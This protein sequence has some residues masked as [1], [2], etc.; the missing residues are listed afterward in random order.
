MWPCLRR[1][2]RQHY[3]PLHHYIF[4]FCLWHYTYNSNISHICKIIMEKLAASKRSKFCVI[5][6]STHLM[7]S[8]SSSPLF[9]SCGKLIA[10]GKCLSQEV[11]LYPTLIRQATIVRWLTTH[12][13]EEKDSL[14]KIQASLWK[15][16]IEDSKRYYF[17]IWNPAWGRLE[18]PPYVSTSSISC[19]KIVT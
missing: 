13:S 17:T 19:L 6:V 12:R 5:G 16:E 10:R 11:S 1:V 9:N 2:T 4:I 3:I 7:N 15:R 14:G 18:R 8:L